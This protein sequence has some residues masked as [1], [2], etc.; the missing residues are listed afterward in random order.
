MDKW[1]NKTWHAHT[2]E[3]YLFENKKKWSTDKC[4]NVDEPQKHYVKWKDLFT[5]D[6]TLYESIH[7]IWPEQRNL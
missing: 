2:M 4:Y 1:I 3:Y 5:K 7:M 6:R